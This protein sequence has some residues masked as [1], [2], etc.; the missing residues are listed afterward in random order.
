VTAAVDSRI[1]V[2]EH[3]DR[4]EVTVPSSSTP[5]MDYVLRFYAQPGQEFRV[6]CP[7]RGFEYRRKCQHIMRAT[8]WLADHGYIVERDGGWVRA[9]Q[10]RIVPDDGAASFEAWLSR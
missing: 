8:L 6:S 2:T 10:L 4:L 7:C 5:G 1:S 9:G 3:D